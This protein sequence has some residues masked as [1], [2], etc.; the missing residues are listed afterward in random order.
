MVRSEKGQTGLF[1]AANRVNAIS[2]NQSLM[3]GKVKWVEVRVPKV[4]VTPSLLAP[5]LI[6]MLVFYDLILE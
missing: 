2:K 4:V 6:L 1:E 3:Y 5:L